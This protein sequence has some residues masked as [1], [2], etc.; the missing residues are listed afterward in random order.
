MTKNNLKIV[1]SGKNQEVENKE[2]N[3]IQKLKTLLKTPTVAVILEP[4]VQGAGG[5]NMV[6]PQFIKKVYSEWHETS[7]VYSIMH[8]ELVLYP[9]GITFFFHGPRILDPQKL[10][11]S[12]V[13]SAVLQSVSAVM[14]FMR[15]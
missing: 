9:A 15:K 6:R 11:D 14:Q 13:G 4:L 10:A 12:A 7:A 1:K 8:G 3:A 2:N 5:M